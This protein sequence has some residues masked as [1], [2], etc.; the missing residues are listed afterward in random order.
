MLKE[1]SFEQR[2]THPCITLVIVNHRQVGTTDIF[3]ALGFFWFSY[4][5]ERKLDGTRGIWTC[6]DCHT[7]FLCL[8]TCSRLLECGNQGLI[9]E[10]LV[11]QTRFI[12]VEYL[13]CGWLV[14][15]KF[16]SLQGQ[17]S[18]VVTLAESPDSSSRSRECTINNT[19]L[20]SI[21]SEWECSCL[22]KSRALARMMDPVIETP[23]SLFSLNQMYSA[24]SKCS[25]FPRFM[26]LAD[27]S[28]TPQI[29][30]SS[31]VR[32]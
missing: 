5:Q 9:G 21:S 16:L 28:L 19:S 20:P 3:E 10:K 15:W 22:C 32:T 30:H 26:I 24:V 25:S 23:S 7:F 8:A 2:F 29:F 31:L 4:Q 1:P 6:I 27:G 14:G 17:L 11:I 13:I 12:A 18:D